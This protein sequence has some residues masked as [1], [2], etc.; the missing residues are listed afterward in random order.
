MR[1]VGI[2]DGG[3]IL[4]ARYLL[5]I[6]FEGISY[7]RSG[8]FVDV[9]RQVL[10]EFIFAWEFE[11]LKD[12]QVK[13]RDSSTLIEEERSKSVRRHGLEEGQEYWIGSMTSRC[14]VQNLERARDV[15]GRM[16]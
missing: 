9:R 1:D 5:Q 12:I 11:T 10:D 15:V 14:I 3:D 2:V 6:D 7:K 8:T 4:K 16:V 13:K